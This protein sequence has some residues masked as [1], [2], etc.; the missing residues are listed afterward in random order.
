MKVGAEAFYAF[1]NLKCEF[2]EDFLNMVIAIFSIFCFSHFFKQNFNRFFQG[3]HCGMGEPPTLTKTTWWMQAKGLLFCTF[4]ILSAIMG[5]VYVLTP[6]LPLMFINHRFWR[7]LIDRLIGFWML[8]PCVSFSFAPFC[9]NF[10]EESFQL[11]HQ[12]LGQSFR[13]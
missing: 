5:S 12:K 9:Q 10:P 8:M 3:F 11:S 7:R 13:I 1:K 2:F 6:L 4:V